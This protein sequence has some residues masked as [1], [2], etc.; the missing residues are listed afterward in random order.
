MS[1]GF[2]RAA[3]PELPEEYPKSPFSAGGV[4]IGISGI[5]LG[6]S[7]TMPASSWA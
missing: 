5:A 3:A 6:W 7:S 1:S 2:G 4:I